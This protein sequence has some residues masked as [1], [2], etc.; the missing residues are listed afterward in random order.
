MRCAHANVV[1]LKPLSIFETALLLNLNHHAQI[2]RFQSVI[3]RDR[4][5]AAVEM[6]CNVDHC[7]YDDF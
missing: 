7:I 4:C 6:G 1:V 5:D 2:F 3:D